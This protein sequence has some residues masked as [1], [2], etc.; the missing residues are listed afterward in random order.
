MHPTFAIIIF[1]GRLLTIKTG[2]MPRL[3]K[4]I[5]TTEIIHHHQLYIHSGMNTQ[6]GFCDLAI[7]SLKQMAN[8]KFTLSS[9]TK[10]KLNWLKAQWV[11][12]TCRNLQAKVIKTAAFCHNRAL[13][14][15]YPA[16]YRLLFTTGSFTLTASPLSSEP[17][18][19]RVQRLRT[20]G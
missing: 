10:Q 1:T 19:Q 9:A 20:E 7:L 6:G 2:S 4:K 17:D 18:V 11:N 12:E 5:T 14:D 3:G 13:Q 16:S 8:R 15:L